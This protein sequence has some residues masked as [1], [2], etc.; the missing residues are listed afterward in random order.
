MHLKK[1]LKSIKKNLHT[2]EHLFATIR[3]VYTHLSE[4]S[5]EEILHYYHVKTITELA[6][7]IK[8]IKEQLKN[9]AEN[10][11][12]RLQ[13]LDTCFCVDSKGDFKYLYFTKKEA[14][15]QIKHS[16]ETRR[17]KLKLYPCPF[18]CGWHLSKV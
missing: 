10:Y 2:K 5:N 14:E 9:K 16:F 11:E 18:H 6:E 13:E 1:S 8:T 17:I 7:H 3:G 15:V 4:L 12:N